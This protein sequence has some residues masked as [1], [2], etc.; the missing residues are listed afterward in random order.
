MMP[1]VSTTK[2][3]PAA[4][5]DLCFARRKW[6]GIFCP[7][8]IKTLSVDRYAGEDREVSLLVVGMVYLVSAGIY[9]LKK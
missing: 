7:S 2:S 4:T 3:E 8:E 6:T 5:P 9:S 1:E